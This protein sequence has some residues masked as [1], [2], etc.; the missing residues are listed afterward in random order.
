MKCRNLLRFV[1]DGRKL[2][3]QDLNLDK[4]S[5]NLLC[6]RYTTGYKLL[7]SV[8]HVLRRTVVYHGTIAATCEN[9][10]GRLLRFVLWALP[11]LR[12]RIAARTVFLVYSSND[13]WLAA[14]R[15][16]TSRSRAPLC[17]AA[18]HNEFVRRTISSRGMR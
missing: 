5:Q 16:G 1:A 6:Y 18:N 2:P 3:G 17:M 7:I 14:M 12:T 4:E 11:D 9:R 13:L 10:K 8:Y 15:S